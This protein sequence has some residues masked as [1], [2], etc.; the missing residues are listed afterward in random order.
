MENIPKKDLLVMKFLHYFITEKNYN[1]VIVHGIQDEIWLE[2]MNAEYKIIRIVISYIHNNEQLEFDNYKVQKLVKQI[3][4]KTFSF[5]MKVM[6][7]YLDL[8]D[9]L[10]LE[11]TKLNTMVNAVSDKKLLENDKVKSY[12]PDIESKLKFTE[13][14][15]ALYEK[16]NSDILKKNLEENEKINELFEP[17]KP[18][19][20][21]SLIVVMSLLLIIMGVIGNL[22]IDTVDIKTLYLMGGLVKDNNPIRLFSSI[23]LHIGVIHFIMNMWSLYIIGREVENFYG[24][25][26]TFIIFIVSGV[27]GNLMTLVLMNKNSISAG[28]S[29]AIFGLMGALLYFAINQRT[30]MGNSLKN[31]ILPVIIANLLIGMMIPSI[32]LIAHIGGLVGGILISTA[33]GIKYKTTRFEKINGIITTIILIVVLSYIIYFK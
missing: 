3:K 16:I 31:Q 12:F 28:A 18:I 23:F 9:D 11:N 5:N 8:N 6:S 26:K 32:N 19:I 27:V 30:I 4:Y 33:L 20:T 24:H 13:E 15:Q 25:I 29:G 7:F 1:P 17:K 22:S 14:G 2:N 10:K 21:I